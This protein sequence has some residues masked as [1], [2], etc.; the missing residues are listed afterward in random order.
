MIRFESLFEKEIRI[1]LVKGYDASFGGA[2]VR[3][4]I[5]SP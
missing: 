5:I 3:K 2:V 1:R 4:K